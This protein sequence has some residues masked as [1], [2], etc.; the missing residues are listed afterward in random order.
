VQVCLLD[1]CSVFGTPLTALAQISDR[2]AQSS[3]QV[4][5]VTEIAQPLDG[6][7]LAELRPAAQ[8]RTTRWVLRRAFLGLVALL[9]VSVGAAMLMDATIDPALEQASE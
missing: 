6:R 9:S 2:R 4:L 1:I 8:L 5:P 3:P 7:P